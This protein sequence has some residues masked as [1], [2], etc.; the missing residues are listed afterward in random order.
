[1]LFPSDKKRMNQLMAK[2]AKNF[3]LE[4]PTLEQVEKLEEIGKNKKESARKEEIKKKLEKGKQD[5]AEIKRI[6]EDANKLRM[7]LE[8]KQEEDAKFHEYKAMKSDPNSKNAEELPRS[9]KEILR[10]EN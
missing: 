5:A 8:R 3:D 1:M 6:K 10:I 4:V 7:E 9:N 2:A